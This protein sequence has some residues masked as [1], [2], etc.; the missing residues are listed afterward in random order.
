MP[1]GAS[2]DT[3]ARL[4]SVGRRTAMQ[5]G[6]PSRAL[7]LPMVHFCKIHETCTST[8]W[9]EDLSYQA[10][11]VLVCFEFSALQSIVVVSLIHLVFVMPPLT[12]QSDDV[13]SKKQSFIAEL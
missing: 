2:G 12:H 13:V 4:G 3:G 7:N 10:S 5:A 8:L 11:R 9:N 1:G 6:P